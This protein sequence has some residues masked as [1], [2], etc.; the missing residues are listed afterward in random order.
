MGL[1]GKCYALR[2]ANKILQ[3]NMLDLQHE[4]EEVRDKF[5]ANADAVQ[6]LVSIPQLRR[7]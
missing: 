4:L 7:E 3:G 6:K 1:R 2:K 5:S